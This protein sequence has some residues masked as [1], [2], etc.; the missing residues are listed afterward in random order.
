[1]LFRETTGVIVRTGAYF[2]N[3]ITHTNA[4]SGKMKI[5]LALRPFV[6][7]VSKKLEQVKVLLPYCSSFKSVFCV[8]ANKAK[9]LPLHFLDTSVIG[10]FKISAETGK[11]G[12]EGKLSSPGRVCAR[13]MGTLKLTTL[14]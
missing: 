14:K 7:L 11:P 2:K 3:H 4:I 8:C 9:K 13:F 6:H 12:G 1:M 5:S 10:L